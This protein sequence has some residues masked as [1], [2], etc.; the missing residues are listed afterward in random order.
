MISTV[1]ISA[2]TIIAVSSFITGASLIATILL[3]VFLVSKELLRTSTRNKLKLLN[4]SLNVGIIPL[5]IVFAI[6]V[7]LKVFETLA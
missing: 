3:I 5:L 6:I 1:N 4:T 7:G 2:T